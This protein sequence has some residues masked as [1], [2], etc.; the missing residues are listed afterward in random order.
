MHRQ[1]GEK[2][3]EAVSS[4]G[5][6]KVRGNASKDT[7]VLLNEMDGDKREWRGEVVNTG[8]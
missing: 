8:E 1:G 2:Q 5:P 4:L 6:E 7:G 3:W